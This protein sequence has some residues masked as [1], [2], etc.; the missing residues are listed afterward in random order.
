M[1]MCSAENA[2]YTDKKQAAASYKRIHRGG[3]VICWM[4]GSRVHL[5]AAAAVELLVEHVT[6]SP[7]WKK[8][9]LNSKYFT[10]HSDKQI[11]ADSHRTTRARPRWSAAIPMTMKMPYFTFAFS[12]CF[13]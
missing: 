8:Y 10:G 3:R 7:T 2:V 5:R 12:S 9:N 11:N 1:K 6:W 4:A 13:G